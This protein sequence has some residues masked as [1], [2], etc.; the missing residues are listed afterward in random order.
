[1]TLESY[2]A[3]VA[4]ARFAWGRSDCLTVICDWVE[5]RTGRDLFA[6]VRGSYRSGLR[7]AE[8][9]AERG[10]LV[11]T[12]TAACARDGFGETPAPQPGDFGL[13]FLGRPCC[14]LVAPSG[15]WAVKA[16]AGL[17]IG[18]PRVLCAWSLV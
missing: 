13:V 3:E 4:A 18:S 11:S 10:G 9:L 7:A 15:R 17:W 8:L 12:L 14:A 2:L 16:R 5:L 1:M 6:A